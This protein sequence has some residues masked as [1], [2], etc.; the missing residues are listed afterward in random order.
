MGSIKTKIMVIMLLLTIIPLL[1]VSA[2]TISSVNQM[3]SRAIFDLKSMGSENLATA[4]NIGALSIEDSSKALDDK[5]ISSIELR[6]YELSQNIA[7]F[8]REREAEVIYAASLQRTEDA[9][10]GFLGMKSKEVWVSENLKVDKPIYTQIAF[11]DLDGELKLSEGSVIDSIDMFEVSNLKKGQV[12]LSDL[13]GDALKL[14]EAFKGQDGPDGK[15]YEGYYVWITPVYSGNNKIGYVALVMD[16]EHINQFTDNIDPMGDYE[17]ANPASSGNYAYI[18]A[19]DSWV[20]AHPNDFYIK[21]Y[22]NGKLVEGFGGSPADDLTN[23]VTADKL[24]TVE[25]RLLYPTEEELARQKA[26]SS[27]QK[28][29]GYIPLYGAWLTF[30]TGKG[31]PELYF[32][33]LRGEHGSNIYEWEGKTKFVA[34]STIMYGSKYGD[35]VVN[36]NQDAGFGFVG[37]GA[38]LPSFHEAATVT[39]EKINLQTEEQATRMEELISNSE[40]TLN[41]AANAMRTQGLIITLIML[42]VVIVVSLVL[43]KGIADPIK[44][45]NDVASKLTD[46]N[47]DVKMP[48][49]KGNDEVSQLTASMEMLVAGLKARMK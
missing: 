22:V 3:S 44:E 34:M 49:V 7:A 19:H 10:K 39:A 46:G 42:I 33:N 38:N 16:Q 40:V 17:W 8:L 20:I 1:V 13:I 26:R 31:F 45:L 25:D 36:L 37:M 41:A 28:A 43:A 32:M 2:Y 30:A 24:A 11:F 12:Y 6:T 14:S 21:G 47:F 23:F 15:R 48:E 4:K 9:Y 18:I 5:T 29:E 35:R 27:E